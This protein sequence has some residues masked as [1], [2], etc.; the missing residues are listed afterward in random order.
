[1]PFRRASPVFPTDFLATRNCRWCGGAEAADRGVTE[2]TA[3]DPRRRRKSRSIAS[4]T[5]RSCSPSRSA[6][7]SAWPFRGFATTPGVKALGDGFI[8][9]IK[10]VIAPIIFCTVVDGH[11]PYPGRQK[12]RPGRR[13]GAGL[14]RGGL[15]LR[16]RH[17][18]DRRQCAEAGRGL[19]RPCRRRRG[20]QIRRSRIAHRPSIS[21]S[22]SFPN[23]VVGAFA[24]RRH[25]PGSAVLDPDGLRHD[26]DGRARGVA[27]PADRRCRLCRVR[28]HRHR[29]E[30]RAARR[31]RRHGLHRRQISARPCSAACS[32]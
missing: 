13:Q 28:R 11:R 4:F 3:A 25:S 6:S 20:R 16:A 21:C 23:S 5:S 30:G 19:R 26:G 27:A 17:R 8:K 32:A 9:L 15:D 7:W 18:P 1:M 2:W 22:T 10:M 29:D 14:F 12:G 24:T 31:L